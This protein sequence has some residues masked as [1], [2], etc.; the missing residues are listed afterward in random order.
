MNTPMNTPQPTAYSYIRFSS[1]SQ[2]EGR[3]Q[4]RQ[5]EACAKFC[6]ANDLTLA[7]GEDYTFL[8]AGKSGYKAEHLDV[9]GQLRRFLSLVENGTIAPGSYLI[10]E[11]LDRLSREHVKTALPQFMD[12]LNKGINIV[13][14]LDGKTY[15]SCLDMGDHIPTRSLP[16]F[17]ARLLLST[18]LNPV[19]QLPAP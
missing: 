2:S 4:S 17:R 7:Q 12:L 10:V 15:T 6:T 19:T 14:L 13:T 11:S 18:L 8:D 9:N 1:V 5:F 16:F 3:S